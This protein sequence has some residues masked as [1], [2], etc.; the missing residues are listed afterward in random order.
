MFAVTFCCWTPPVSE[1]PGHRFDPS[2]NRAA[3]GILCWVGT[4]ILRVLS[5]LKFETSEVTK[6][7][8]SVIS[9]QVLFPDSSRDI[10]EVSNPKSSE[11]WQT[12]C[13]QKRAG[14]PE[15]EKPSEAG[16][17]PWRGPSHQPFGVTC[18]RSELQKQHPKE[19]EPCRAEVRG[20]LGTAW[21]KMQQ[22]PHKGRPILRGLL[23]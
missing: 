22:R 5:M 6:Y 13:G 21:R 11:N 23:G 7:L 14:N 2:V 3:K 18:L 15:L 16:H 17:H 4:W 1:V 19:F 9:H 8:Y 12:P 10:W 20:G